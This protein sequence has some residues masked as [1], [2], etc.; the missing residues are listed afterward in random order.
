MQTGNRL[1]RVSI[2]TIAMPPLNSFDI[3]YNPRKANIDD[4]YTA[5]IINITNTLGRTLSIAVVDQL[6]SEYEPYA[7]LRKDQLILLLYDS[8]VRIDL[9]TGAM[10]QHVTGQNWG[11]LFEIHPIPDGYIVWGEESILKYD[12]ALNEIW[13][14][15]G[16]DILL[17][18]HLNPSFWI[19]DN[20]IHCRD[21]DGRH[22]LL[23]FNGELLNE[24]REAHDPGA[25]SLHSGQG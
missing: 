10:L 14:F 25:P 23:N 3:V 22:Y 7:K 11:E 6:C 9:N 12:L 20:I 21:F 15:S 17:S 4:F 13:H 24:F 19:E 1:F 5:R 18:F 2:D 16:R 8:I